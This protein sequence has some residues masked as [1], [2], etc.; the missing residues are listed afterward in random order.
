M[1]KEQLMAV[2]CIGLAIGD[3]GRLAWV[4]DDAFISY[5]YAEHLA[6][7]MGLVYN[8][9]EAVEGYTNFLDALTWPWFFL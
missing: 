1:K 3:A 7:G 9:G 8:T 5:R 2:A 4:C 6:S